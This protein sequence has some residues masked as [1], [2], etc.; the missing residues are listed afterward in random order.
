MHNKYFPAG[1]TVRFGKV[2]DSYISARCADADV[3]MNAS[4]MLNH[5]RFLNDKGH[6]TKSARHIYAVEQ[7][8]GFQWVRH[9]H[10]NDRAV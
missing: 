6:Y 3:A 2:G 5:A 9:T 1:K 4:D 10:T 8:P 7:L